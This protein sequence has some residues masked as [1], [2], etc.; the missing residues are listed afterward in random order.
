MT[1]P[2]VTGGGRGRTQEDGKLTDW[3]TLL[4]A[5]QACCEL[6]KCVGPA[7]EDANV[8]FSALHFATV[9]PI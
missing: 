5:A 3:T 1:H 2:R 7:R 8:H 4:E 9:V 6:L